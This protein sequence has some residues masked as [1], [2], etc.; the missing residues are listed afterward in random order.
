MF[1]TVRRNARVFFPKSLREA[2][3]GKGQH[4]FLLL[5]RYRAEPDAG[6]D[7][8]PHQFGMCES[9]PERDLATVAE[10]N[11]ICIPDSLLNEKGDR[12]FRHAFIGQFTARDIGRM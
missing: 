2:V 1:G 12:I 5:C 8:P 11:Q 10:S 6:H 4:S 9:E 7:Y 3:G